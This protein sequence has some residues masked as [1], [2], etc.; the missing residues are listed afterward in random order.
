MVYVFTGLYA[1][2]SL[3]RYSFLIIL[4][5]GQKGTYWHACVHRINIYILNRCVC[6]PL[7]SFAFHLE[8]FV[9]KIVSVDLE[10]ERE[11]NDMSLQGNQ[12]Q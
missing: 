10:G 1:Y 12:G 6:G 3:Q 11:K 4:S 9:R 8:T 5:V 7:F 2:I